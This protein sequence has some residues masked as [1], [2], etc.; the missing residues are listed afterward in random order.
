M[1]LQTA[2]PVA[3][4]AADKEELSFE[5]DYTEKSLAD[6]IEPVNRFMFQFNDKLYFY[7]LKPVAQGYSFILR[8]DMKQAR[9][10]LAEA[11]AMAPGNP[12]IEG[13]WQLA[14]G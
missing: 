7:L 13:N 10:I 1:L 8:G 5:E 12:I 6:P 11:R 9:K 3:G 4:I 14:T 2:A